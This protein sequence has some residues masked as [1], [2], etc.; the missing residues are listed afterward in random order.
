MR[1]G[2][3]RQRQSKT[4]SGWVERDGG[5]AFG[6]APNA[7]SAKWPLGRPLGRCAASGI[8]DYVDSA[9]CGGYPLDELAFTLM[10]PNGFGAGQALHDVDCNVVVRAGP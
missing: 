8:A 2:A 6:A 9:A 7:T 3:A 5:R 1:T 10:G 4:A